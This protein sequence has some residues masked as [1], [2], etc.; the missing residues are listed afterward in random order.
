MVSGMSQ[1]LPRSGR[2]SRGH[3]RWSLLIA[4]GV[5]GVALLPLTGPQAQSATAKTTTKKKSATTV[6]KSATTVKKSTASTTKKSSSTVVP[7]V[8]EPAATATT[9]AASTK[10]P[11]SP[12]VGPSGLVTWFIPGTGKVLDLGSGDV[13]KLAGGARVAIDVRGQQGLAAAGTGSVVLDI[14]AQTPT[15]NGRVTLTPIAASYAQPVVS[16]QAQFVAGATTINRIAVPIGEEAQIRVE[17]SPGPQNLSI[18]VVGWVVTSKPG[19][20]EARGYAM[21]PCRVVDSSTGIGLTGVLTPAR[22]FDIPAAAVGKIPAA[23]AAQPPAMVLVAVSLKDATAVTGLNVLPTGQQ[24]PSLSMTA[25]AGNNPS[26][27]FAIPVGA[28]PRVAFYVT[29]GA[30]NL[31]VD[32]LGYTDKDGNGFSAGPC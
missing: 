13:A 32:L 24:T 16:A 3:R 29:S 11:T 10:P 25:V 17:T 22:P 5:V 18:A 21:Q 20:V 28:D 12:P 4:A 31:T 27:V 2:T 30:A 7:E 8:T 26:G 6:K 9:V 15:Q 14:T 23:S 19:V 1:E